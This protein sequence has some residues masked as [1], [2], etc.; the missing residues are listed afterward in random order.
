MNNPKKVAK[1]LV[2]MFIT[3]HAI[4][5]MSGSLSVLVAVLIGCTYINGIIIGLLWNMEKL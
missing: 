4:L 3:L 1:F 2:L 5:L